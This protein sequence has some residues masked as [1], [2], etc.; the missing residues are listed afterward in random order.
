MAILQDNHD[1]IANNKPIQKSNGST[2]KNHKNL[3]KKEYEQTS[4]NKITQTET[5]DLKEILEK[6]TKEKTTKRK[7]NKSKTQKAR[8]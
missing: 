6:G 1:G 4:K 5:E 3:R 7:N 8:L 2:K